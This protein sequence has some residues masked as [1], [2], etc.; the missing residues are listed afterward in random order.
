MTAE[1]AKTADLEVPDVARLLG[2]SE[3][4]VRRIDKDKLDYWRT[5][6]PHG[7]RKYRLDDVKR[8]AREHQGRDLQA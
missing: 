6:W 2:L 7:R 5:S 1:E 4:T 3:S 8:Y